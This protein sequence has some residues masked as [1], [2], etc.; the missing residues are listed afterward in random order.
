MSNNNQFNDTMGDINNR[1]QDVIEKGNQR[2]VLIRKENGDTLVN[3]TLTTA[4]VGVGVGLIFLSQLVIP[5]A[6]IAIAA[7][8]YTRA[9]IELVREVGDDSQV[10]TVEKAK[11]ADDSNVDAA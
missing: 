4:V 7:G 5:L 2:R 11:N 9:K 6:V 8:V 10:V 1:L 3:V